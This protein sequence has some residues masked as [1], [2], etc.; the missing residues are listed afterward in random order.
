MR[1]NAKELACLAC[2][3]SDQ[4]DKEGVLFVKE[5]QEGFFR[6][7]EGNIC[8]LLLNFR[9]VT[10]HFSHVRDLKFLMSSIEK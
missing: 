3:S 5:R 1:F 4:Y 10:G 6:K 8:R 7:G 2:Q 9:V